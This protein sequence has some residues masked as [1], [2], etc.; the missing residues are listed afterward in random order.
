MES[1]IYP[2]IT[3]EVLC[4]DDLDLVVMLPFLLGDGASGI[5]PL[6]INM[7]A[8]NHRIYKGTSSSKPSMEFVFHVSFRGGGGVC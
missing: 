4:Q 7:E 6:K 2:F 1:K 8:E 3:S 5:H